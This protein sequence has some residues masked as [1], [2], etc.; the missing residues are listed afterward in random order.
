MPVLELIV[1]IKVHQTIASYW[2]TGG[3]LLITVGTVVLTGIAGATLARW[4]GL[5]IARDVL[6][7]MARRESPGPALIDG[8][9]IL[10]GGVLLLTPGFLTDLLGFS[11]L[12]PITRPLHRRVVQ[13]WIKGK[14]Q[15]GEIRTS[16]SMSN[17]PVRNEDIV[18]EVPTK[19]VDDR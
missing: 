16:G 7:R 10:I 19:R 6:G 9:L 11:M 5:G 15:R 2:G 14:I 18:I 8:F 3:G 13:N 4:Q 1:L 17:E 12:L